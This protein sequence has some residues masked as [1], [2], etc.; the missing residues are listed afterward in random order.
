MKIWSILEQNLL[1]LP[2]RQNVSSCGTEENGIKMSHFTMPTYEN[3]DLQS[4]KYSKQIFIKFLL[5]FGF[6]TIG[7]FIIQDFLVARHFISLLL[8]LMFTTLIVL[9]LALRY[10]AEEK[11]KYIF[12]RILITFFLFLF[13]TYLIYTIGMEKTYYRIYWAYLFPILVFFAMG[14]KEGLLWT[15]AFYVCIGL[16]VLF[17]DFRSIAIEPLKTR[18][19]ISFFLVSFMSFLSAYL[20]RRDRQAL[21]TNQ[22]TLRNEIKER[23]IA[24]E[25]LTRSEQRYR[26][27]AESAQ[28]FIFIVDRDG[29][30]QYVNDSCAKEFAC[31]PGDMTRRNIEDFFSPEIS[32]RQLKNIQAVFDSGKSLNL[33]VQTTFPNR[34]LWLDT[35]IIPLREEGDKT[36][37]VLGISR[38]ITERKLAEEALRENEERYRSL[39]ESEEDAIF[40][41]SPTGIITSLSPVFEKITGWPCTD[42]IGKIFTSILHPGDSQMATELYH[43]LLKGEIISR[44]ELRILLKSGEYG[45]GEFTITPQIEKGSVKGLLGIARDITERKQ[46]GEALRRSEEEFRLTFENA[47]DAIFW[48]DPETG[49]IT[50]CNK[51]AETLLEKRKEEIIGGHQTMLHPP[52]KAEYYTHL[53]KKHLEQQK[54]ADEEAEVIT[55]SGK[56]KPVHITASLT[57]V[58]GQPIIQGIFRDITERRRVEESLR[59]S[60]ERYRTIL[61]NIEDGYYEADLAG[62]LTF[63]NE[64]LCRMLGYSKDEMTGMGNN[65]YTDEE[66]RKKLYQAFNEVYRTGKSKKG[67]DWEVTRKDG[68]KVFGEASISLIKDS[69]GQPIGFRGI[70]RDITERKRAEEELKHTLS[71]L[72]ATLESTADGILVVDREGKIESFN[73][74]FAQMWHIPEPIIAS[75]DDDRALAFVLD[76]LKD[77]EGFLAK[78]RELYNQ[79]AAESFD[80]LEFKDGRVFERYSQPQRIGERSVGRVWSFRD[81]TEH[82]R[83]DEAL[84]TEKQ[85][86]QSLSENAPFGMMMIDPKGQFKYINPKFVELFGYDLEDVPNGKEWFRRA[87]PDSV[88]RHHVISTWVKDLESSDPGEKRSRTFTVTC[89]DGT[90]KIINF[91][92]VQLRTGENLMTCEDITERK[93]A[94][95]ALR[96]SEER[97]RTILENIEDGYYETD[98]PGDLTFF[99]DSLCKMLGYSKDEMLG[100]PNKQYTDEENREKLFQAFNEVYRTGEPTKGFDWQVV[101]K[102][103]RKLFGEVSVSLIRGSEGQPTGFRGIARDITE[104]KQAEEALRTEKQR[105]ERL[106]ENAPFGVILIGKEGN[107]KYVNS[108]FIELFGYDLKDIPN[109]KEWFKKAYPDPDYRHQVIETWIHDSNTSAPGENV[110]RIFTAACKDGTKKI[111]RFITVQLGTGE[112]LM[113]CED[114]T[115]VQRAEEEKAALAEQLRQSQKMEAIGRLAGGIAHDFNNLLTVIRGYSQLS[116]LELK[117]DDNVREHIE[118]VQRATQRATDLTRQLLAFG[119]RQIMEMRI[120]D[121][122]ALLK[123]LD[124]M[125]HRVIGEDI[126]LTYRLTKDIGQVKVDAGQIEQVILNLAVN[127]RDAMPSGGKLTIETSNAELDEAYAHVHI[128]SKPGRYVMLSV[129]DTGVGMTPEIRERAFDPFF[130]TKEKGKG[131]GL[132]LS[133]CYGIVKQS[134]GNIWAYSEPGR[135]TTL[136]IYLPRL[137]ESLKEAKEEDKTVEILKG[138]ETILAV[139]DEIEVRKLVAQI[140]TGQGY[141]VIEASDGEDAIRVAEKN[142]ENNIHLL[143]TDVV[144]PGMSGHELAVLLGVSHPKMKVLYMSGYTDNAI[145]HHGVLEEGVNYIQKPFTLDALARKVREVLDQK[146]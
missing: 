87:Y 86:F 3:D 16:L 25:A 138:S 15:S 134:G 125:L 140:L 144:M 124:K 146:G 39:I 36:T 101:R 50:N 112:Y 38:D 18:F 43:R 83:A 4:E 70:A 76:Q 104:R 69:K 109:G 2:K 20:L 114:I 107:F 77:P 80:L 102:D 44:V 98:L 137:D 142:S 51:E 41:L 68:R 135:G 28:D 45:F 46:A 1:F 128:G 131:T 12:Y 23:E 71:L 27:L 29:N 10:R 73:R 32:S 92:P 8:L 66:N 14:L 99:N 40:T 122:N 117:A 6:P 89:K 110:P 30:V 132:G 47:K 129:S 113:S 78:V 145:V 59:E 141:R 133:T 121:L 37:S 74:K 67:F 31:L 48:A 120:L 126:E 65:Q 56:I 84:R 34:K 119:R 33:E 143:L 75:R 118:E 63:F 13:G 127:A 81:V 19:L 53:F 26:A 17:S 106:L 60:E 52:Q 93:R 91:T 85:R 64:A 21:L 72:N 94:E 123:D 79:P 90:Q 116:L 55:K 54:V 97:Y 58:G 139:E 96:E 5:I 108:K 22:Q 7:Y 11:K 9:F 49:L 111:S 130:T 103:G 35:Q 42:W 62:N 82:K 95:E 57:L 88:Y 136:K 61:E 24:Q 115:L 105:F 100:M